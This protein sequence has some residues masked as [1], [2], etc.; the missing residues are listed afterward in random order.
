MP[1]VYKAASGGIPASYALVIPPDWSDP[2]RLTYSI[3]SEQV[4]GATGIEYRVPGHRYMRVRQAYSATLDETEAAS[5]REALAAMG[6][7]TRVAVPLWPDV[8]ASSWMH[9]GQYTFSYSA[10]GAVAYESGSTGPFT[11]A[12]NG[13]L[14]FGRLT[15]RPTITPIGGALWLVS[16][17]VQE[18][19]PYTL[20]IDAVSGTTPTTFEWLPDWSNEISDL[21]R[22]QLRPVSIGQ[23]RETG[24]SGTNGTPRWG[25]EAGFTLDRTEAARLLRFW[26]AKRGACDSFDADAWGHP[27]TSTTAT[28]D[29]YTARFDADRLTLSFTTPTCI[30]T[31]IKLWQELDEGTQSGDGRALLASFTWEGGTTT[32]LTSWEHALT[33]SSNSYAPS[34]IKKS[35]L[36]KTM[37]PLGDE[38]DIEIWAE[39]PGNP[40]APL[41]AG[42]AERKLNVTIGEAVVNSSGTVT[43][44]AETF[45]GTVRSVEL[46]SDLLVGRAAAYGAVFARKLPAFVIQ[47]RCNYVLFSGPCGLSAAA[48]DVTGTIG[49]T[50]PNVTVTFTP[51]SA[52]T[53]TYKN[54]WFAGGWLTVTGTDSSE[55]RR[56]ILDCSESTGV[57]TLKL[58][59]ALPAPCSGQTATAYPGCDGNYTTCKDKFSNGPNFGGHPYTPSFIA[60]SNGNGTT[61][62]A[63]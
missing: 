53:G 58:N 45:T 31:T 1:V 17:E 24:M 18:D 20:R 55:N 15:E 47:Q 14:L 19:S 46:K 36:R 41:L 59:R 27:G 28:P 51:G 16:I 43:S 52:P 62:K 42:E 2:V 39:E 3:A 32:R 56:A 30:E 5:L 40:L 9:V 13:P 34:Q 37:S 63:K 11:H 12:N 54:K 38:C 7:G 23:G 26:V 33:Y 21:S 60:T 29:T 44:Y 8:Y 57:W 61:A 6:A 49:G 35:Q 48:W 10:A 50:L 4:E 25:Q 22:D